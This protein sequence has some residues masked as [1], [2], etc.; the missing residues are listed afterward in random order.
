MLDWFFG[1]YPYICLSVLAVGLV[2][3]YVA[4]PGQWNARS[5]ELFE[6]TAL[7]IG[8]PVFHFAILLSFMGHVGG[9][10]PPQKLLA[11]F[12]LS[13]DVHLAIATFMGKF[14]AP[15][16]LAGLGLLLYRRLHVPEVRATTV[17]M[18]ITVV[19]L[20]LINASTGFYQAFI[21]HFGV[22]TT[23]AP[24]LRSVLTL[25]PD[26]TLMSTVPLFMQLH[27]VSACT[28]FAL[29]PFSRLIHLFSAP[30]TYVIRP[31]IVYRK[32]YGNI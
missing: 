14:L 28:L 3:R 11:A 1:I 6:R 24:W 10:L 17:P 2:F 9:L 4:T 13:T 19:V 29:L 23:V 12:G 18:D 8:S 21:A 32:R 30:F 25:S 22:F 15:L 7:R 26:P 27:V 31:F 20:I 5:S 16:V